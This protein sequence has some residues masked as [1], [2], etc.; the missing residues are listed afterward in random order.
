MLK[1]KPRDDILKITLVTVLLLLVMSLPALAQSWEYH[2]N[3]DEHVINTDKTGA[4]VDTDLHEIRLPKINPSAVSFWGDPDLFDYIALTPDGVVRYMFDGTQMSP[5]KVVDIAP[6]SNPVSAVACGPAP[7]VM[8]AHDNGSTMNVSHYSFTGSEWVE[9][10][11]LAI[12]G[13]NNVMSIDSRDIDKVVLTQDKLL[14]Y[15]FDG[16]ETVQVPALSVESGLSNPIDLAL[17]NDSYDSVVIDGQDIKYYKNGGLTNTLTGQ[18]GA[19]SI[20]SSDGG[21]IAF[22]AGKEVRHYN[23]LGDG[24]FA[25][26]EVLSVTSGLTAPTC[27]ALRPGSFD[28]IIV[29]GDNIKYYMWDGSSLVYNP[30]LSV[31]VEGLKDIGFYAPQAAAE[32]KTYT[33]LN[34]KGQPVTVTHIKMSALE[35][36][37][38]ETSIKW[39]VTATNDEE[40]G[41]NWQECTLDTWQPVEEGQNVRWKAVLATTDRNKTPKI[42]P[43]IKIEVNSRPDPPVPD[44]PSP[45]SPDP[46]KQA[47]YTSSTPVLRWEFKDPD[48][49][50]SQSA[51]QVII[52][53]DASG[54]NVIEDSGKVLSATSEYVIDPN[55][56]GRLW[57]TGT[58]HFY[59]KM[60]V[61]DQADVD[62]LFSVPTRICVTAFDHPVAK[63]I[64]M[65]SSSNNPITKRMPDSLLPI[66]KAGGLVTLEVD[67]MGVN[68]FIASFPYGAGKNAVIAEEP[69]LVDGV[70]TATNKR[71]KVSFYTDANTTIC[72][73]GTIVGGLFAGNGRQMMILEGKENSYGTPPAPGTSKW[74]EWP[75][76]RWWAEGAVKINESAFQTWS[77]V[78][79]GRKK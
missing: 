53:T 67:S 46:D 10:P 61:W 12:Q 36:K 48:S 70:G 77:V 28:R 75:G 78:L 47:C 52:S 44:I 73:D 42:K 13:L 33:P 35:D 9:N 15:A 26:N 51:F 8:V 18:P 74:W 22:V 37:P 27:V 5:V 4:V 34:E 25:H 3:S 45:D 1:R 17:L 66:T 54:T 50:D 55:G 29:D 7:D 49:E 71:W 65:P 41:S 23:I 63:Q 30:Q 20:S 19:I 64:I 39:Y 31:M 79:Q 40:D 76:Y 58:D 57:N 56:T 21:N 43:V 24:S 62:S 14:Y 16:S 69:V 72:P 38:E 6:L 68:S 11:N 32:S 60:K 2:I 59:V